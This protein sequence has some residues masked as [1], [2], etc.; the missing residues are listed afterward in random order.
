MGNL[1]QRKHM[2]LERYDY[3]AAGA[4]FITICVRNRQ[5]I[6]S[7]VGT[8]VLDGPLVRLTSYGAT[9]EKH[10]LQMNEVYQHI[11]AEK[12]VIMPNHIHLLLAVRGN[13]RYVASADSSTVAVTDE[14]S[15][16][17]GTP[18][19]TEVADTGMTIPSPK[20]NHRNS[21]VS[22]YIS[23]FKRFCNKDFG[24]NIWQARSYDHIIRSPQDYNDHLRY[25]HENPLRWRYD[26]L[27]TDEEY[28]HH[29]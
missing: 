6:L 13:G 5:C 18:V 8:G 24:E 19:P 9:A 28:V 7:H 17:S 4:Y 21:A 10:I 25:I 2:R 27:Y 23:T 12:Y 15:G 14:E 29:V 11:R 20:Q 3:S 1:P 22:Q 16:P 26:E